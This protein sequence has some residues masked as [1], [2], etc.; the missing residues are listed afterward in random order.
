MFLPKMTLIT[1]KYCPWAAGRGVVEVKK[2][3]CGVWLFAANLGVLEGERHISSA[4]LFNECPGSVGKGVKRELLLTKVGLEPAL[5]AQRDVNDAE[6]FS[7]ILRL[8]SHLSHTMEKLQGAEGALL[9]TSWGSKE[10]VG[11]GRE[12]CSEQ[13]PSVSK[14]PLRG[15]GGPWIPPSSERTGFIWL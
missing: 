2:V 14:E 15:A 8:I 7:C 9:S 11:A 4:Y 3:L 12:S 5:A 6:F 10:S 1:Q 13:Q